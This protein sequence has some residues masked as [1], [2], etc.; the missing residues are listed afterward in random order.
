MIS[1]GKMTR[2]GIFLVFTAAF[3]TA[4]HGAYAQTDPAADCLNAVA[5]YVACLASNDDCT[6]CDAEFMPLDPSS[7]SFNL[8]E[9]VCPAVNCCQTCADAARGFYQCFVGSL[10]T[11]DFDISG[12]DLI[13]DPT[14]YPYTNEGTASDSPCA[15]EESAFA[16]CIVRDACLS[17]CTETSLA[18]LG[19]EQSGGMPDCAAGQ[20]I[21]DVLS[22][23][24]PTCGDEVLAALQCTDENDPNISCSF[25]LENSGSS[26]GEGTGVS[27]GGGAGGSTG[28]EEAGGDTAGE[29]TEA[30]TGGDSLGMDNGS[31]GGDG[32]SGGGM[33]LCPES[34]MVMGMVALL[35]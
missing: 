5:D 1:K 11:A 27:T 32:T 13:C 9:A 10:C 35:L 16:G 17:S 33:T 34:F 28:G 20:T 4:R 26:G 31:G 23:C 29:G 12:C 8:E 18:G 21:I 7:T 30:L 24:C 6:D 22:G 3:G 14:T 25:A 2:F 15:Q 19:D